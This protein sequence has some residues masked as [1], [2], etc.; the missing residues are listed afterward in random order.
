MIGIAVSAP[1]E[2]EDAIVREAA[3]NG[4]RVAVRA[5][6]AAY[7]YAVPCTEPGLPKPKPSDSSAATC[8]GAVYRPGWPVVGRPATSSRCA[9]FA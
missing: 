4:H 8:S 2:R 1:L 9:N 5:A 3:R 6:T 7:S